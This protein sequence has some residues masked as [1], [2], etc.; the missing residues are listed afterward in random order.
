MSTDKARKFG[1]TSAE[2]AKKN[3][4]KFDIPIPESPPTGDRIV[5]KRN[6]GRALT[7]EELRVFSEAYHDN[8]ST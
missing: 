3:K 4:E 1:K 8:I 5:L 7:D 2:M 6:L